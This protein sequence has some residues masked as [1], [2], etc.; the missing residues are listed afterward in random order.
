MSVWSENQSKLLSECVSKGPLTVGGDGRADSPGHSAMYGSYG[1]IDLS[2]NT[3]IHIELVQ[4]SICL[5][6]YCLVIY[7]SVITEQ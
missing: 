2:S 7:L 1:I 6:S 3:A 5:C 4:V